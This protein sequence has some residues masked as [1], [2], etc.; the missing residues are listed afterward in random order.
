MAALDKSAV[1]GVVGAGTMGAGIAQ[2]AAAAGYSVRLFDAAEG[3]A[4]TALDGI[5]VSLSR[6][7]AKGKKTADDVAALLARIEPVGDLRD[8]AGV[9]L[10]VEAIVEDLAAKTSLFA[11]LEDVA[12]ED[13]IFASNTSSISITAIARDL[14]KPE[15]LAGFHF[16]NPA[17]IMKLVEVVS[18][19]ATDRIVADTLFDTALAFGKV[20]VHARS[21]PG[22]IVNRVARPYYGE[23]LRLFE[24]QVADPATIDALLTDGGGFRM[25][26]FALMDLIGNDVNY[27]VSTSVFEA[28]HQD[29]RYRPSMMQGELVRAGRLGRKSGR[30]FFAY[31]DGAEQPRPS[32]FDAAKGASPLADFAIGQSIE[33]Q[34]TF[35]SPTDGRSAS[36]RSRAEGR[37]VV[38]YDHVGNPDATRM[39]FACSSDV[40]VSVIN[41]FATTLAASNVTATKLPDWPGLVVTRTLAMLVNEAFEAQ[42]LGV[43]DE[44][45]IDA[46]LKYGVNYPLGP[47]EWGRAVGLSRMLAVLDAIHDA[48]RDPRYR[49]SYALRRAADLG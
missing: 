22:F 44:A 2:V 4:K 15:R 9:S 23:A 42:M 1:L 18:G 6:L 8:L 16:F 25:G 49:A 29:P 46:A 32:Q 27:A 11:A 5:D 17:P 39:G 47:A 24:E 45:S 48:T 36:T 33:V 13:A 43:A 10:V 19:L 28:F 34:G 30:G 7:V 14:K 26:P 35:I 12:A 31:R 21:T 40:P 41:S 3:A 38:V 37:P 20:P